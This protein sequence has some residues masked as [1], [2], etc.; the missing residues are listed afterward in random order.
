MSIIYTIVTYRLHDQD[1][2]H[3]YI[4]MYKSCISVYI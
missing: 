2:K 4:Y 3:T 1:I